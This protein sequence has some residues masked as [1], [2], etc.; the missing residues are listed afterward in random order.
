[1][2][3]DAGLMQE[4]ACM[5]FLAR[6][7]EG[8]HVANFHVRELFDFERSGRGLKGGGDQSAWSRCTGLVAGLTILVE[9]ILRH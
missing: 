4:M 6:L 1:M 8:G 9:V 5:A 7:I 3:R 2:A